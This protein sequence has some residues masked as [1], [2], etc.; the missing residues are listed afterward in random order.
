MFLAHWVCRN[1]ITGVSED[2]MHRKSFSEVSE[3]PHAYAETYP[4]EHAEFL[5]ITGVSEDPMHRNSF[6]EVSED[7]HA[8]SETYLPEH[9]AFLRIPCTR[10]PLVEFLRIPVHSDTPP[11]LLRNQDSGTPGAQKLNYTRISEDS[12]RI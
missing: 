1:S 9:A 4:P 12:L 6:S 8:D 7:P 11:T 3:D 5:K 10:T 2:P